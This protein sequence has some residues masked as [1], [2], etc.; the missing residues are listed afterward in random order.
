M[1]VAP[2]ALLPGERVCWEGR[3]VRHQLYRPQDMVAVP[4]G[5]LWAGG[6]AFF[7]VQ[8][9]FSEGLDYSAVMSTVHVLLAVYFLAGRFVFR[10]IVSRRTRYVL[11]D[12]R[13]LVIGG[14]S[15]IRTTAFY[16]RPLRPPVITEAPDGSGDLA[17]GAFPGIWTGMPRYASWVPRYQLWTW[18]SDP[19]PTPVLWNVPHVRWVRDLVVAAQRPAGAQLG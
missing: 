15:G 2:L 8:V 19:Y 1:G 3:P 18:A 5:A 7:A 9:W 10:A 11:T 16:L 12:Q 13:L 14:L 6:A 17:F 4:I